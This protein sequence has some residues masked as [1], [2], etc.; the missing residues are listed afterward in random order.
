M[1]AGAR[2]YEKPL[3]TAA[4]PRY[5]QSMEILICRTNEAMYPVSAK[6]IR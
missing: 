2:I 5:N 4:L 1:H 6:Q 3:T